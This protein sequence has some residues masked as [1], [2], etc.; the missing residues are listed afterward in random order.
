MAEIRQQNKSFTG[1]IVLTMLA[2]FV[3]PFM[4]SSV[5]LALPQ[6][7]AEFGMHA[8]SMSWIAMSYI[9]AS[10]VFLLPFGALSDIVGR[11]KIFITR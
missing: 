8:E 5:N 4:G 3:T 7:S 6:I 11:K 1:L 9:L 10:A 2:S